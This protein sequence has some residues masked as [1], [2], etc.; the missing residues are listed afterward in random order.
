MMF[1]ITEEEE[2]ASRQQHFCFIQ[3]GR[4]FTCT[5]KDWQTH[6]YIAVEHI[7]NRTWRVIE[8]GRHNRQR[9]LN[10]VLD[11]VPVDDTP[12]DNPFYSAE[13]HR[14]MHLDLYVEEICFDDMR[15]LQVLSLKRLYP[16]KIDRSTRDRAERS[17]AADRHNPDNWEDAT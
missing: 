10:Q 1:V 4:M 7:G 8:L 5:R 3:P 16:Y 2:F 15:N 11:T 12:E 9:M 17:L 13:R 6:Y 14:R